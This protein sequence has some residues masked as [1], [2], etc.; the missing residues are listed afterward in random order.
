QSAEAMAAVEHA[1]ALDPN[2]AEAHAVKAQVLQM[3]G[4]L[5][6]ALV[7][8]N[9]ALKL[10]PESYEVN[11]WAARLNYQ[12]NRFEVAIPFLEKAMALMESDVNSPFLLMSSY[13]ALG[14]TANACRVAELALKR[15][16]ALLVHDP[17]NPLATVCSVEALIQLGEPERAGT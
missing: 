2:L 12:L 5:E 8:A 14:D 4:K 6:A 15:A 11:R 17:N 16:D 1:L 13:G 7:E 10:D 3:D 9:L